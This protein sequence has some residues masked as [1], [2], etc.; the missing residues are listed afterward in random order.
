MTK[1]YVVHVEY[2]YV[3]LAEDAS[4]ARSMAREAAGDLML[5][6][7][8]CAEEYAG[9]LP[10]GWDAKCLVY[11]DQGRTDISVPQAIEMAST[12]K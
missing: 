9:R 4:A 2:D 1:L 12:R 6:D 8:C 5:D 7:W 3:A 10:I 11:H